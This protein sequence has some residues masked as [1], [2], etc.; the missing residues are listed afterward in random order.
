MGSAK[1]MDL[2]TVRRFRPRVRARDVEL[3]K[4]NQW[5]WVT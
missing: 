5:H 3:F 2:E 4:G 1:L